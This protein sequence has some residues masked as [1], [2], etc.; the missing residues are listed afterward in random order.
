[1]T[2]ANNSDK[3]EAENR[4]RVMLGI[5]PQKA[6]GKQP[7][8]TGLLSVIAGG[9]IAT[10]LALAG[11]FAVQDQFSHLL[12]EL[13][14]SCAA[15]PTSP[16]CSLIDRL[17]RELLERT[18]AMLLLQILCAVLILVGLSAIAF[19]GHRLLIRRLASALQPA[20]RL[21]AQEP[22]D[23][24][25]FDRMAVRRRTF[26]LHSV[27]EIIDIFS[28]SE[29]SEWALLE[30]MGLVERTLSAR[31]VAIVL[32]AASRQVL[33]SSETLCTR[34]TPRLSSI[35]L[36]SMGGGEMFAR[37]L[38]QGSNDSGQALVVSMQCRARPVGTLLI[39]LYPGAQADETHLRLA[40]LFA[41]IAAIAIAGLSDSVEERRGALLEERSAIAAEL[42]DSLAQSLAFM[43]I[44]VARL[45][46]S[47]G[48]HAPDGESAR[49]AAEL[50]TGISAAYGEVREL[51]A[52]FR[53][54]ISDAGL[55]ASLEEAIHAVEARYGIAIQLEHELGRCRLDVNE[56]FHI[57]Q[58]VRES[59]SNVV[60]HSGARWARVS[61][62]Y[63]PGHQIEVVVEDD[64]RGMEAPLESTDHYGLSIMQ[65]RSALLGGQLTVGQRGGGGTRLQL[66][67]SPKRLP[68]EASFETAA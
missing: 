48:E 21:A 43:K 26:T 62:S 32:E 66:L 14:A 6:L 16:P 47:V 50:R 36:E 4:N 25:E 53:T 59:L 8:Y 46:K 22:V 5:L 45:Q 30:A 52:A 23:G 41:R 56:Q 60:R 12:A 33:G 24:D 27:Q 31:S 9:A 65:E 57:L 19:Q 29:A 44:Q 39:E 17:D 38:P 54:R 10:L 1:M 34:Q 61:L 63:G 2:A 67:F 55:I 68:A 58:L 49:I 35:P 28:C 42:H 20:S 18:S 11:S 37:L 13:T 7:L 40:E 3:A 15:A 64:G 51:I